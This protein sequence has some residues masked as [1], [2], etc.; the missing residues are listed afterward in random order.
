MVWALWLESLIRTYVVGAAFQ[1]EGQLTPLQP[2]AAQAFEAAE[3]ER[4][5]KERGRA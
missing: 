3:V 2:R 5:S 4:K 1:M